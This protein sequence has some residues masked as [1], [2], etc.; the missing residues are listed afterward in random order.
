M[1]FTELERH[2]KT[3]FR[4]KSHIFGLFG[5]G[6]GLGPNK[7]V[8]F[9]GLLCLLRSFFSALSAQSSA[10]QRH[11]L[12]SVS[13]KVTG[14]THQSQ[15]PSTADRA[16]LLSF[17]REGDAAGG[18]ARWAP[19]GPPWTTQRCPAQTKE[20]SGRAGNHFPPSWPD[21]P[22]RKPEQS[23]PKACRL[24]PRPA[25]WVFSGKSPG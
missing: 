22:L 11:T 23:W 25:L 5:F 13:A 21:F 1:I 9:E 8:L 19:P 14:G 6:L 10:A 17:V 12:P 4:S 16:D 18:F 20:G 2:T 7:M 15:L 3:V 24:N